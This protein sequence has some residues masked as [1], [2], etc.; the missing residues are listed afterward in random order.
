MDPHETSN[1]HQPSNE[2]NFIDRDFEKHQE[3]GSLAV[4]ESRD[5]I[6]NPP[7]MPISSESYEYVD[8]E[9]ANNYQEEKVTQYDPEGQPQHQQYN[10]EYDHNVQ[11]ANY[12]L[13]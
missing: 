11:N 2:P 9:A 8:H 4:Q 5:Y 7:S 13:N 10:E 6:N 1:A 3:I 12:N